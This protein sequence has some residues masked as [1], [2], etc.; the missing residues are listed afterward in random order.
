M[1][2]GALYRDV[3]HLP[4]PVEPAE[5]RLR[6]GRLL[7]GRRAVV[8]RATLDTNLIK[9]YYLSPRNEDTLFMRVPPGA[10][11]IVVAKGLDEYWARYVEIKELLHLFDDPMHTT[12]TG[13]ELENLLTG[14]CES[15]DPDRADRSPQEQSEY[16]CEWM[17]LAL[18]SPEVVRV[19][20]MREREAMRITD[21][22][23][24]AR[25]G[26]PE[27]LVPAIMSAE[28]KA[29]LAWLQEKYP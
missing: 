15:V 22:Q 11:V 10:A 23:I 7:N 12:N 16:E 4:V 19:D 3:Q 8:V 13:T 17:A 14:L 2:F 9:G 26:V 20:L 21:S 18:M 28:Y 29:S 1:S 25:L 24:A 5:I 6:I 27:A